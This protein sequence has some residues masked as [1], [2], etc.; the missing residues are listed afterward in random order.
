MTLDELH[1]REVSLRFLS[2]LKGNLTK[3]YVGENDINDNIVILVF[4]DGKFVILGV[5]KSGESGIPQIH[6]SLACELNYKNLLEAGAISQKEFDDLQNESLQGSI[7]W[8][9]SQAIFACRHMK[10]RIW[11]P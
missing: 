10:K 3:T 11:R 6:A 7:E 1:E 9:R 5:E 2:D 8:R 4:D